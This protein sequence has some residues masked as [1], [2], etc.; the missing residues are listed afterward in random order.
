MRN[1]TLFCA[2]LFLFSSFRVTGQKVDEMPN[3]LL[4]SKM[5]QVTFRENKGQVH[6]QKLLPRPDVLFSGIS[7]GLTFHI[8]NSGVSYQMSKV[9]SWKLTNNQPTGPVQSFSAIQRAD[10][11]PEKLSIY[12]TDIEWI[13]ANQNFEILP[14]TETDGF[15]NYYLPSCPEG[16]MGVRAFKTVTFKNIFEGV[17]IKWYEKNGLLEYDFIVKPFMDYS[18]I[19]WGINGAQ[20]IRIGKEGQLQINTPFGVIEEKAPIAFQGKKEVFVEWKV[21]GNKIGFIVSDYDPSEELVIDPVVRLWST[22]YGGI[23]ADQAYSSSTDSMGNIYLTGHTGSH[24]SIATTGAY[25]T[26]IIDSSVEA[27]IAK[28]NSSGVRQWGTYYGGSGTDYG[29]SSALDGNGNIYMLGATNSASG[30]STSGS[31]QNSLAGGWDAFLVKFNPLGAR[32]WATY[33]GGSGTEEGK[34]C[35]TDTAGNIYIHG[36]TNSSSG[37]ATSGA[38]SNSMSGS[39][40]TFLAKFNSSGA[41]QWATYFGGNGSEEGKACATDQTGNIFVVGMTNSSTGLATTGAHQSSLGGNWDAFIVKFNSAGSRIW[42]TYYGGSAWD[43]SEACTTDPNG[44]VFLAGYTQ[45]TNGISSSGAYQTSY[46]GNTD[47]ILIKFNSNGVRQWGTYYGGSSSDNGYSCATNPNGDIFLFGNTYSTSGIATSGSFQTFYSGGG[48]GFLVKFDSAGS[49]EWGSYIGSNSSE[50]GYSVTTNNQGNIFIAGYTGSS[51]GIASSGAHQTSLAGGQDAFL[52]KLADCDIQLTID[53]VQS[54]KCF[55]GKDG[56]AVAIAS[57]SHQ[58]FSYFWSDSTTSYIADSLSSGIYHVTI[59]DQ[60]GC[61]ILDSTTILQ[62]SALITSINS[63]NSRCFGS[64]DGSAKLNVSGGT[65]N[66]IYMWSNNSGL[67][68]ISGLL[69]NVYFVTVTDSNNC[70]AIDS[71]KITEPSRISLNASSISTLCY[72]SSDGKAYAIASGGTGHKTFAW[73]NNMQGDTISGLLAARYTVT[74]SDSNSCQDSASVTISEPSKV[75]IN[76]IYKDIS[77]Y[78]QTNGIARAVSTGGSGS[79]TYFWSNNS[80]LDSISSL[81]KGKYFVTV[82]DSNQCQ[83]SANFTISEP[84]PILISTSNISASCK[85]KNDG[86]AKTSATGG[87]GPIKFSW[88][89]NDITDSISGISTGWYFVTATDSNGC[90]AKDSVLVSYTYENPLV[91]LGNDS[92]VCQSIN[93]EIDAQNNGATFLWNTGASSKSIFTTDSGSFSVLVTDSNGCSSSDTIRIF[94]KACVMDGLNEYSMKRISVFPNPTRGEITIVYHDSFN[95]EIL[96]VKGEVIHSGNAMESAVLDLTN[97]SAGSYLLKL[98][99]SN[100]VG[101]QRIIKIE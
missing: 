42:A 63:N 62:P 93:L 30:I 45:S 92:T 28:F 95:F 46:S 64:S 4:V 7:R 20:D 79:K 58:P 22:Y 24:S 47:A 8:H 57:S 101:F 72:G 73:S 91:L 66:K 82:T 69:A 67:D 65:G 29:Y 39:W 89:T 2:A 6:D 53:S 34:S 10:S 40:D 26:T 54:V 75:I 60:A 100:G 86:G 88:N 19:K 52:F 25:Q 41:R 87:V 71:V 44:N 94:R 37:I 78:G 68:S 14:G 27:F 99:T 80:R 16:V 50:T 38:H 83:D 33:Y 5:D 70:Q 36:Y 56:K 74:V 9:E 49:R 17:D 1:S 12:R 59:A 18:L 32:Q 35:T 23:E 85:N 90:M 55:G 11:V 31:Y 43:Y 84:T 81:P 15:E 76:V 51:A 97:N 3:G 48:D 77:C 21:D 61:T 98:S 96:N 13:G